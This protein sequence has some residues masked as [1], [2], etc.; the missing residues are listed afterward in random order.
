MSNCSLR[1]RSR[2]SENAQAIPAVIALVLFTASV[3]AQCGQ[4][5]KMRS[6][7]VCVP[8]GWTTQVR[9]DGDVLLVCDSSK[10]C[11]TFFGAPPKGLTFLFIRPVEGSDGRPIDEGPR[12]FVESAPHAGLPAPAVS[13]VELGPGPS[14]AQ[15][16]CFMSRRLL[17][18]AGAWE[19]HY[20]LRVGDR[21][22]SIWTRY[23]NR[24]DRVDEYRTAHPGDPVLYR[25]EVK[26]ISHLPQRTILPDDA[27][28]EGTTHH[29]GAGAVPCTCVR[30]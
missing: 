17:S 6:Y 19:E 1:A 29:P 20:G 2:R 23:E 11:A 21:L 24:P 22:F 26:T 10:P 15:R 4:M 30:A 3:L 27:R 5:V 12:Q 13:E 14:G 9:S 7:A 16:L 28:P 18:W 8:S 25:Y